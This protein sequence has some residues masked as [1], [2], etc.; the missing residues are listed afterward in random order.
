VSDAPASAGE[1]AHAF[2]RD[3]PTVARWASLALTGLLPLYPLVPRFPLFGPLGTD[4]LIPLLA[5][6]T[7]AAA[8]LV[9]GVWRGGRTP[10]LTMLAVLGAI[11]TLAA[12][13]TAAG[14]GDA[15]VAFARVAGRLSLYA[16]LV[17]A[18]ARVLTGAER[19]R[20]LAVI[21]CVAV[22]EGFL[23]V[24][25]YVGKIQG[26]WQTGM[27][28]YPAAEM[29]EHGR[30]RVQGTFGGATPEGQPF[31][32]RANFYSA[33]LVMGLAALGVFLGERRSRLWAL[34]GAA[35]VVGGILASFSR[36]SLAAALVAVLALALLT[37]HGRTLAVVAV[38]VTLVLLLVGPIR[39]RFLALDTDRVQQ[40]RIAA[41]VIGAH[42][43]LGAGD[44]RYLAEAERLAQG[45]EVPV[46][47]TP[48]NSVLY[49]AASYGIPAGL[50][51]IALYV[52]MVRTVADVWRRRR[53]VTAA[54]LTSLTAAFLLHDVTNN[55][56]FIPEVALV[57]W[58]TFAA[59]ETG[60]D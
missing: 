12:M 7:A 53:T 50:A 54:A 27:L 11:A 47:R 14:V 15:I 60:D 48:H 43:A 52:T 24:A 40:W 13:L 32:N 57:F 26:P 22:L 44:Q 9:T 25:A 2:G 37:R 28:A 8:V 49:A 38:V 17:L 6:G 23:G 5:I 51:L 35:I 36:M 56:F 58:M 59:T 46:V 33:Y 41:R 19:R 20:L 18:I 30:V 16:V 1:V 31:L 3:R 34:A 21:A 39:D 55:L 10:V 29:P 4:D 45:I 42:P